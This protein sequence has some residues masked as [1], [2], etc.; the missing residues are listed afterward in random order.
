MS[1]GQLEDELAEL[2]II[3]FDNFKTFAM[4]LRGER[5][6]IWKRWM[7]TGNRMRI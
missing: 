3:G 2:Q 5:N 6:M 1:V 4:D 7:S